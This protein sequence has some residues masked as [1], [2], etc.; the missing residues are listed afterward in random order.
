[1]KK[2]IR[3]MGKIRRREENKRKKMKRGK[4]EKSDTGHISNSEINGGRTHVLFE[5]DE[6]C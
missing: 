1:M 2:I 5:T 6:E 3:R 4:I